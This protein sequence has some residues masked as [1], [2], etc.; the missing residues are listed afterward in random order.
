MRTPIRLRLS[1]T[2]LTVLLLGMG[3]AATL[4]WLS[5][6]QL[7]INT[8]QE[9]L[10]AQAQLTASALQDTSFPITFTEPYSQTANVQPGI[11]TRLLGEQGAVVLNLPIAEDNSPAQVPLAENSASV[12]NV[13]LLQRPEIQSALMGTPAT[14]VRKVAS[15]GDHRVMYAAAPVFA[16][17]GNINGIVYLATPLP[18]ASLPAGVIWQLLHL[19]ASWGGGDCYFV[20][21]NYWD[22]VIPTYCPA[23]GKPGTCCRVGR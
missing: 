19:A 4:S 20:S 17:D 2:T 13:D 8:Q 21:R 12:S 14:A 16:N 3:L 15:A 10:L 11:H 23:F 6:E 5:V 18:S 9:N 22:I 1:L 7:Y